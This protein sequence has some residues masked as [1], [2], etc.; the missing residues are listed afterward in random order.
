[1][2]S[3]LRARYLS[4]RVL[5]ATPA[6]RVVMLYDRLHL[7][8]AR[9]C[10]A[11]DPADRGSHLD[12]AL[13]VIAELAGSLDVRAGGPA[14]NLAALYGYLVGELV[15]V[16]GGQTGR[17]AGTQSI[18]ETLRA[19]W[20]AAVGLAAGAAMTSAGAPVRDGKSP[21][22]AAMAPARDI[23]PAV[24]GGSWVG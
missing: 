21:S 23:A 10:G 22:D 19:A 7:D 14:E 16:R 24:A 3:D 17:L 6:Q 12:H 18:V 4:D 11:A 13:Q 15:A 20:T 8:L 9:A 5:T 2:T 1:M